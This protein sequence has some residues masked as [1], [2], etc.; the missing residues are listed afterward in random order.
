MK[1]QI[2]KCPECGNEDFYVNEEKGEIICKHCGL[3][4]EDKMILAKSGASLRG[5]LDLKGEE[6]HL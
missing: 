5:V 6:V 4:I 3:V 1:T 2:K